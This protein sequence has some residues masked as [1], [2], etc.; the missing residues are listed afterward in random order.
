MKND[1]YSIVI[2]KDSVCSTAPVVDMHVH[3]AI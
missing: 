2:L 1:I 3:M